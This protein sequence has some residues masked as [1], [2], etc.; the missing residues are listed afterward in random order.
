VDLSIRH[1][2]R[3]TDTVAYRVSPGYSRIE[4][5]GVSY[6]QDAPTCLPEQQEALGLMWTFLDLTSPNQKIRHD[7]ISNFRR[8]FQKRTARPSTSRAGLFAKT[9]HPTWTTYASPPFQK[10]LSVFVMWD[11]HD[12]LILKSGGFFNMDFILSRRLLAVVWDL[13]GLGLLLKS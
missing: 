13:L 9:A 6:S 4:T 3:G 12:L 7:F 1:F 11:S 8:L 2:S 10:R 5:G